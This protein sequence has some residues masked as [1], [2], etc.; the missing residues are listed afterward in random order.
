MTDPSFEGQANVVA[1]ADRVRPLRSWRSSQTA[2]L[3]PPVLALASRGGNACAGPAGGA[4]IC[5]VSLT[6]DRVGSSLSRSMAR[7]DAT[8]PGHGDRSVGTLG[9]LRWRLRFKAGAHQLAD[10]YARR[11]VTELRQRIGVRRRGSCEE[12]AIRARKVLPHA[13]RCAAKILTP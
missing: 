11:E 8:V 1:L 4:A 9:A 7:T 6:T 2:A 13:A 12:P 10:P 5:R 3:H